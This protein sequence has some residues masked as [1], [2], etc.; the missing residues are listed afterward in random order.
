[1]ALLMLA[2][3]TASRPNTSQMKTLALQGGGF[4]AQSVDTGFLTG[5]LAFAGEQMQVP[6]TLEDTQ[7]LD[8]FQAV[9]TNSGSSW[10]FSELAYSQ[11]FKN[12]VEA[13]ASDPG[14]VAATYRTNWTNRLVAATAPKSKLLEDV[15]RWLVK[16]LLGAGADEDLVFMVQYFLATGLAWNQFVDV[17]LASTSGV[18]P[19]TTLGSSPSGAWAKGKVPLVL[20]ARPA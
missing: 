18:L 5:M 4:R 12:L 8:G 9:S 13:M 1:M 19:N 16:E 10:F 17:L 7:L 15:E 20:C 6:P 3:A 14:S 2:P 11:P